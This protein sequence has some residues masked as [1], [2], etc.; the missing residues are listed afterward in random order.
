MKLYP[1]ASD[2]ATF[3]PKNVS[4]LR[5]LHYE[6]SAA[7]ASTSPYQRLT[8]QRSLHL[9][10]SADSN[11]F[12][13][14]QQAMRLQFAGRQSIFATLFGP[15]TTMLIARSP[16]CT[17]TSGPWRAH[18]LL[19]LLAGGRSWPARTPAE[20]SLE[21]GLT[22]TQAPLPRI[23]PAIAISSSKSPPFTRPAL[24]LP[25]DFRLSKEF[26][27]LVCLV[28]WAASARVGTCWKTTRAASLINPNTQVP[29]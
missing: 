7:N 6:D 26:F 14:I 13:N 2:Q 11:L 24:G 3:T 16:K 1:L 27:P 23:S 8:Q 9:L 29:L 22:R 15:G 12:S 4:R 25:L 28:S 20:R 5:G 21:R 19:M 18:P 17:W 10:V